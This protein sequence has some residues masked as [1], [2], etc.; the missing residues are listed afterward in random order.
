LDGL[1]DSSDDEPWLK[2]FNRS[3]N[4]VPIDLIISSLLALLLLL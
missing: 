4:K 2:D 1:D 3:Q